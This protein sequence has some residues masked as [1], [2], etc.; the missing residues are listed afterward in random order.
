MRGSSLALHRF[1]V[2]LRNGPA[3]FG[4]SNKQELQLALGGAPKITPPAVVS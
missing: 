2:T 1:Y 3:I 4:I